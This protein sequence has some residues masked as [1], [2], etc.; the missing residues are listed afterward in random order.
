LRWGWPLFF[1]FWQAFYLGRTMIA[2]KVYSNITYYDAVS[3]LWI[4][5]Q[6][7]FA[8]LVARLTLLPLRIGQPFYSSWWLVSQFDIKCLWLPLLRSA[9]YI[10]PVF[11]A[12]Q[13]IEWFIFFGE[14]LYFLLTQQETN[15]WKNI[16]EDYI[17]GIYCFLLILFRRRIEI[18]L[19]AGAPGL[20]REALRRGNIAFREWIQNHAELPSAPDAEGAS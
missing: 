11:L 20:P 3:F 10:L 13:A 4:L 18:F 2:H 15:L 6:F 12:F 7:L 8:F 16:R 19:M 5:T 14:P 17:L 9:L 1:G